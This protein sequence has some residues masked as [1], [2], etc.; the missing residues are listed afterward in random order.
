MLERQLEKELNNVIE[1]AQKGNINN[2]ED[3]VNAGNPVME[4][5]PRQCRA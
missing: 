3:C 4:S 1:L 2:F 5:Y